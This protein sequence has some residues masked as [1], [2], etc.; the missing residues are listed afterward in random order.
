MSPKQLVV[1]GKKECIRCHEWKILEDFVKSNRT[2]TGL[3]G[4][5]KDCQNISNSLKYHMDR[6]FKEKAKLQKKKSQIKRLYNISFEDYDRFLEIQDNCCAICRI[7]FDKSKPSTTPHIDHDH[8]TNK[9]RGLLCPLCNVGL[10]SFRDNE[11]YLFSAINYL[12]DNK[13]V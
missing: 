13:K 8:I 4:H 1:D 2:S 3:T 9:V 12:K 6:D 10:G 5:C 7:P 11:S